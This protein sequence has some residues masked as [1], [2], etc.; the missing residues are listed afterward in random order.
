M[1]ANGF[2][3]SRQARPYLSAVFFSSSMIR[4]W[5]SVARFEFS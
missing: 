3:W 5:W 1:P 2:S 4:F